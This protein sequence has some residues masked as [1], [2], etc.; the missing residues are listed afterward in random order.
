MLESVFTLIII[1][2]NSWMKKILPTKMTWTWIFKWG[3]KKIKKE[4]KNTVKYNSID[5]RI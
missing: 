2:K 3:I 5:T 1:V 4:E